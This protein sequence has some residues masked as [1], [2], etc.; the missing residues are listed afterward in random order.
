[1]RAWDK[2]PGMGR[3][4]PRENLWVRCLTVK[5]AIRRGTQRKTA[6]EKNSKG[7]PGFSR[8]CQQ[9]S[10][11]EAFRYECDDVNR[12]DLEKLQRGKGEGENPLPK[13]GRGRI[14]SNIKLMCPFTKDERK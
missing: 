10:A 7:F 6:I 13:G 11:K 3:E 2:L 8:F 4:G 1:M 5:K 14:P 12:Q 9:T